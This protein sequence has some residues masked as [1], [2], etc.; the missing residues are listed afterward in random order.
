MK[1]RSRERFPAYLT[2]PQRLALKARKVY[3][4]TATRLS[5]WR[6]ARRPLD[7]LLHD[8]VNGA[9]LK[10]NPALPNP[11]EA[12]NKCA[13][14]TEDDLQRPDIR[15]VAEGLCALKDTLTSRGLRF[16]NTAGNFLPR[17]YLPGSE[18]GKLWENAWLAHHAGLQPNHTVLDV[19]GASTIFSFYAASLGCRIDVVDNDWANCGTLINAGYVA[20]R[21]GWRLR[22]WNRDVTRPLPFEDNRFDRAFSICVLEHLPP[23]VRQTLMREMGRVLKPGGIIGLTVDYDASRPVLLTDKGLRFAYREKLERDVIQP[24]GLRVYGPSQ[25][26]DVCPPHIFLGALFLYKPHSSS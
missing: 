5:E 7:P 17:E 19:G 24:S 22:A 3:R 14:W 9:P 1:E 25:W 16:T 10:E 4:Q 6:A 23:R 15:R 12:I 21:M 8:G 2:G 13:Q 26:T 11:P 18:R 20:D